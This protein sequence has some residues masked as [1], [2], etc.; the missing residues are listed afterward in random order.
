[1]KIQKHNPAFTLIEILIVIIIIGILAAA[2]IPRLQSAK[3]R[4]ND[5]ARKADMQQIA[6]SLVAYQNDL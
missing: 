1:M 3:G 6:T 4:A 2:L 5:T